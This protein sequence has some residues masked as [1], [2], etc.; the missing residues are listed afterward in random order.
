VQVS[1][2]PSSD[3]TFF[4]QAVSSEITFERSNNGE[5]TGLTIRQEG[6]HLQATRVQ[7]HNENTK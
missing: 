2:Q 3:T 1:E 7:Q 6:E 4:A 5:V